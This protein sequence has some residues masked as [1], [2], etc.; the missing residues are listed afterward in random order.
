MIVR[1]VVRF[2]DDRL[3]SS[4]FV[5]AALEKVFPDHWSF[6]IGEICVYAFAALLLT[7]TDLA[8]FFND[9]SAPTVYHGAYASLVGRSVPASYA[10]VLDISF[11]S[12]LG[13]LIRQMHHWAALVFVGAIVFH[14]MRVFFT[15]AFRRPRE[16][17]WIV[18]VT[19]LLLAM[20]EGFF[21]YSLPGDLLSGAGIRIAYS[22]AE[23]IPLVGTWLAI[24]FFGGTFPSDA[25]TPRLYIAHVWIVPLVFSG[26]IA[27]HLG[28][29]WRQHHTQFAGVGRT[30]E[31][32]VGSALWPR[33]A[34]KSLALF[35]ATLAVLAFLGGFFTINPIWIYGPYDGW[36]I[37]SPA[38]PDWYVA[39]LDGAL[40]L[41]PA[42]EIHLFGH[43]ISP[44]FWSGVVMPGLLFGG[45]FAWPFVE[46]FLT[47]D[48]REHNIDDM[49]F[50]APWRLGA[51]VAVFTF[52]TAIGFAG[53]DDIQAKLFHISVERLMVAYRVLA[54]VAPPLCGLLAV[55]LGFELRSRFR[56]RAGRDQV[57]RASIRRNAEGGFEEERVAEPA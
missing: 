46:R 21:G 34:I 5:R 27:A 6:M 19:L 38:Q 10:S 17:N 23:S 52:V 3:G 22:V 15:G 50:D 28:M 30:E 2:F 20:A 47:G 40:R 53:S 36:T 39:W 8:F 41:G 16:L 44:V 24:G 48:G 4:A 43:T 42:L 18:G 33:Y 1:R 7:G 51:G 35:S 49:P 29:I 32:V 37:A 31:N 26:A 45:L 13:L 55:G 11:A 56:S 54:L 14:M 9:S 12:K 25:T 57:R